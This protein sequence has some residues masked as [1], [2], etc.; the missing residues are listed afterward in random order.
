MQ[1]TPEM[2]GRAKS[3]A[4][5]LLYGLGSTALAAELKIEKESAARQ[6]ED[7]KKSL[8]GVSA[9]LNG[10]VDSC[11]STKY[12]QTL[13]GRRRYLEAISSKVGGARDR[14]AGWVGGWG[15]G[16]GG[17]GGGRIELVY[18]AVDVSSE[19]MECGSVV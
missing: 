18:K 14:E 5:G 13:A 3:I 17:G 2:R 10:V 12:I 6:A 9:W 8:P 15:G 16:G 19:G 1:V 7:F 11:R 4:Y